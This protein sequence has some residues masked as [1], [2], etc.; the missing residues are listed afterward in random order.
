[1]IKH[2]AFNSCNQDWRKVDE[3]T[4]IQILADYQNPKWDITLPD[5][6]LKYFDVYIDND[7]HIDTFVK[8]VKWL[9]LDVEIYNQGLAQDVHDMRVEHI[10]Y[11]GQ[12][13]FRMSSDYV[14]LNNLGIDLDDVIEWNELYLT[15]GYAMKHTQRKS[16]EQLLMIHKI[17][18][19]SICKDMGMTKRQSYLT[20]FE[21]LQML[22]FKDYNSADVDKRCDVLKAEHYAYSKNLTKAFSKDNQIV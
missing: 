4:L 18:L 7:E 3:D 14:L 1:M 10:I 17:A 16:D 22:D 21:L 5:K 20:V 2:P 6:M 11:R 12:T 9:A 19:Y 15:V 13:L 8:Q